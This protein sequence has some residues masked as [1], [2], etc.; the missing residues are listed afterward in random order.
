MPKILEGFKNF[1]LR[2]NAVDLAVGVVIGAAFNGLIQG[3]VKDLLTPLIGAIAK[4]PNFSNLSF[5][6][7]GSKFLYGD[8]INSV[9]SFLLVAVAIY[10]FV[11][12]PM[13]A[14]MSKTAKKGQKPTFQKCPEC[15][16]DIPFE[17][18]RCSHCS[19][20]IKKN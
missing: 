15:L 14:I 18:K 5:T 7:N 4:V 17:A 9:I 16:S 13:N 2:G 11:I 19:Q 1:I 6:L 3:I 8:L 12:L 10:F 20:I